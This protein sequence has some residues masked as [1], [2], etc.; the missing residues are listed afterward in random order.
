MAFRMFLTISALAA[1]GASS[2]ALAGTPI[3]PPGNPCLMN[4][5]NPC[6]GNNG[7][8]G[9]QGM[10]RRSGCISTGGRLRWP[11]RCRR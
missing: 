6:R 10:P 1:L 3:T 11:F 7:N 2:P 4:N 8:L 9:A 5:G